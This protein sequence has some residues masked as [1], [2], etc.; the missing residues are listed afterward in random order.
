MN[1]KKEIIFVTVSMG[2]GGTER[3]ISILANYYVSM[4]NRVTILLIADNR[5]E[6]KLDKR[7][8]VESIAGATGGSLKARIERIFKLRRSI[9][10]QGNANVI[11]MGTVT[12]MFTLL[13]TI[14]LSNDVVISERND[15]NRLNHKP[16]SKSAKLLR[17]FLYRRAKAIVLQTED[18]KECFPLYLVRKSVVIPNPLPSDLPYVDETIVRDK[19]IITAGRLTEQKNQQL[20]IRAFKRISEKYPDYVLKIFGRGE[21]EDDLLD[22]IRE[23]QLEGKAQ[24][25]GFSNNL[26][27]ELM[28]GGIYVST[29]NWE[30]ISN[31]LAEALAMGIPT[32]A[33]DCPMGGSRM[34]IN[35]GQNGLLISME[36]EEALVQSMEQMMIDITF[37]CMVSTNA[38]KIRE[39]L[40]EDKIA[41]KWL[42]CFE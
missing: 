21:M 3:V 5:V 40:S 29:S 6:Y 1:D 22:M 39:V 27:H 16:I 9:K 8:K 17:N 15:P 38:V 4:G 32:I 36:D 30:G 19:S 25:K 10:S 31:S 13:A 2:G 24:L 42:K 37:R 34:L 18:V 33:T 7:I 11:A 12:A 20:L 28:N 23:N 35:H 26:H 14:G 41:E